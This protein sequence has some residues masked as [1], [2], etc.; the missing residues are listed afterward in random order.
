MRRASLRGHTGSPTERLNNFI[1][2]R[3]ERE[4]KN[5]LKE[6]SPVCEASNDRCRSSAVGAGKYDPNKVDFLDRILKTE[7]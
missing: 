7:F 3:I 5:D 6:S 4:L 2:M 1:M